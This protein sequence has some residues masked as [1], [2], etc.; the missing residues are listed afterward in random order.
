[1]VVNDNLCLGASTAR[2]ALSFLGGR[3]N[4]G[5]AAGSNGNFSFLVNHIH[6]FIHHNAL[7]TL[8]ALTFLNAP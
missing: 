8:D 2:P 7:A 4:T 5:D 6:E 1:M 3:S